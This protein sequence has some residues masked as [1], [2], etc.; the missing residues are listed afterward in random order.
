MKKAGILCIVLLLFLCACTAKDLPQSTESPSKQESVAFSVATTDTHITQSTS[1]SD[2]LK[3]E[4]E[5][6]DNV[7]LPTNLSE[8]T[9]SVFSDIHW[10]YYEFDLDGDGVKELLRGLETG[11][12]GKIGIEAIKVNR[13]GTYVDTGFEGYQG[14]FE[15]G[16]DQ[17]PI[18]FAD[19]TLRT[20]G[21][22]WDYDH[23]FYIYWRLNNSEMKIYKEIHYYDDGDIDDVRYTLKDIDSDYKEIEITKADFDRIKREMEENKE[24]VKLDWKQVDYMP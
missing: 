1:E 11:N 2:V 19:G 16:G 22:S 21:R 24:I 10:Y 13:N 7:N 17:L 6:T 8:S 14:N 18:L 20:G 12:D 5:A 3:R 4:T 15:F 9:S 23:E